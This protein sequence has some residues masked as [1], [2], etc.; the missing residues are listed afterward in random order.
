MDNS[1]F[2]AQMRRACNIEIDG[3]KR[4]LENETR[5]KNGLIKNVEKLRKEVNVLQGDDYKS[6]NIWK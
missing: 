4:K 1:E 6:L 2:A 5:A 3:F